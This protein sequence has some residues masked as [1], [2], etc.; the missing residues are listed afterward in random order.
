MNAVVLGRRALAVL[1]LLAAAAAGPDAVARTCEL[2]IAGDDH[3]R[4]D[5]DE[6]VVEADCDRV[7]LTLTHAGELDARTMGHNWVLTRTSDFKR[8][9]QAGISAGADND[10]VSPDDERVL[11]YTEIIGGGETTSVTFDTDILES[12]GDYTFFCSFPG[13][14]GV[15][16][17]TLVVE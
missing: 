4:F 9:A 8:V 11:A 16:N 14:Y 7:T 10:Y 15:M 3:I 2:E 17:G 12:G 5:R 6:L 13:H 1:V